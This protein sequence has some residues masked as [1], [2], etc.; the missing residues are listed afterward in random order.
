M[1]RP[2]RSPSIRM[3]FARPAA[4]PRH[5]SAPRTGFV[6]LAGTALLALCAAVPLLASAAN[7]GENKN[8]QLYKWVD[9]KGVTHYGDAVPPQYADQDKTVMNNQGIPVGAIPGR[10]TPEQLEAAARARAAEERAQ[11][12]KIMAR[13]RDQNL[14]ATYLT[15]DEIESLRDRRLDILESQAKV[16]SQYLETLRQRL[17]GY[18]TQA[19]K[20]LPY[21]G[22]ARAVPM[23]ERLADDLVR[24][25]NEIRSQQ[26]NLD[27]KKQ[28]AL[29][30]TEQFSRDIA[31]FK[32]LKKIESDYL[33]SAQPRS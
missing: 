30:L 11:Q 28:E 13:Q 29:R 22:D 16:T 18:E 12:E 14:L 17:H 7:P 6:P 3:R 19:Q 1:V 25:V 9:E 26:R 31:R 15:V 33:R 4:E 27:Q 32:E 24:T 2:A 20:F 23:P 8:L 5:R 10:R 21:N